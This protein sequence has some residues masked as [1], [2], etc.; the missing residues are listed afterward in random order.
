MNRFLILYLYVSHF[1]SIND[2]P[3]NHKSSPPPPPCATVNLQP[4]RTSLTS[5][6][7]R[8]SESLSLNFHNPP[9]PPRLSPLLT[10]LRRLHAHQF[11]R[12]RFTSLVLLRRFQIRVRGERDRGVI[13]GVRNGKLRLGIF[14]R[15]NVMA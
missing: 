15:N 14:K 4:R 11:P 5:T 13:F 2:G 6:N 8:S 7:R 12:L 10:R 3:V 1:Y 9:P